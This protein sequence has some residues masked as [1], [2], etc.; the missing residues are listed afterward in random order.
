VPSREEKRLAVIM[1]AKTNTENLERTART[2]MPDPWDDEAEEFD[3]EASTYIAGEHGPDP[4]P[5]WVITS[6]DARQVELGLLKTGKEADVHL[7]ERRH[8]DSVNV[9]AAKRYRKFEER[10]FK[11]DAR[12]RAARKTG[13]SH[14]DKAMAQGNKVGMAFRARLWLAAE[15]ETLCRLWSAGVPVPYPVQKLGNELMIELIGSPE[16]AAP[17]VV[18]AHLRGAALD[19]AWKQLVDAMH[20]MVRCGIVHGDLSVYN[21]LWDD[22]RLVIIDFPQSVDPVAHPEGIALLERDVANVTDWFSRRGVKCEAS[23][24][25]TS[26]L[27]EAFQT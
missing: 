17:R 15:F 2:L 26:L 12:Y 23:E 9:L 1:A 22:G 27:S 8:G 16:E 21:L 20:A 25:F 14:V 18:H 5:D 13:A 7:V 24:L 4:V 3:P 19:D 6:G 10:L 11:N